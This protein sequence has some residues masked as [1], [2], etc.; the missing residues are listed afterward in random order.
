M[1]VYNGGGSDI[2]LDQISYD[3]YSVD[4]AVKGV[5]NDCDVGYDNC[6]GDD[7]DF[8]DDGKLYWWL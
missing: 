5:G 6:D 4:D 7:N 8:N 1:I 2:R 3:Y